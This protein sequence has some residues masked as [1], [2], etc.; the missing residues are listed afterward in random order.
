VRDERYEGLSRRGGLDM[1]GEE[2]EDSGRACWRETGQRVG[3]GGWVRG[4][5]KRHEGEESLGS[6]LRATPSSTGEYKAV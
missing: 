3:V 5:W 6:F 4:G 2:E 1:K